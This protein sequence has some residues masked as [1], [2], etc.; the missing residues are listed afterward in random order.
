MEWDIKPHTLYTIFMPTEEDLSSLRGYIL[1]ETTPEG[2]VE[3][4]MQLAVHGDNLVT[5]NFDATTITG[6]EDL[7]NYTLTL[8][9]RPGTL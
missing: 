4:T 5:A 7:R 1:L 3:D 9:I 6:I 2:R 8:Q